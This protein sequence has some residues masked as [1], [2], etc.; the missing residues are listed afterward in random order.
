MFKQIKYFQSVV[1]NN[2]FTIAAEE[3]FISQSAISQQIKALEQE[4]GAELLKRSRRSFTLTPAG[5]YFYKKS[6]VLMSDLEAVKKETLRIAGGHDEQSLKIGV[7][8]GFNDKEI[9]YAAAEF[10]AGF[11]DVLVE[12][13][14]GNHDELYEKLRNNA[15]DMAINDQRRKFS[16]E[17]LNEILAEREYCI[18]ISSKSLISG[19]DSIEISDLK[20]IPCILLSN[21]TQQAAEQNFYTNDMGFKSDIIFFERLEDARMSLV[22]GKGYMPLEG[23]EKQIL[24]GDVTKKILLTRDGKPIMRRY[25]AFAKANNTARYAEDFIRILKKEYE[26]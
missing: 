7:V 13:C 8:R 14:Y 17:Y 25:C 22:Q 23:G 12:I 18:E 19:L 20:N 11:P 3:C 16:D 26:V 9:Q 2:S 24:L 4:L 5:E 15:I 10:A 1:R 21:K 6:L